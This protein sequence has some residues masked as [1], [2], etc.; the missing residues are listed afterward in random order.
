MI[1]MN[2]LMMLSFLLLSNFIIEQPK[3]QV[4]LNV[5]IGLH[6]NWGPQGVYAEYYYMPE[7]EV[8]YHVPSARF[9]FWGGRDWIFASS[10]P[11]QFG[12]IDLFNA[13]KVIINEPRPYLFHNQIMARYNRPGRWGGRNQFGYDNRYRNEERM[14]RGNYN[15]RDDVYG[16]N[17]GKQERN[18]E[19]GEERRFERGRGRNMEGGHRHW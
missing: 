8:Y 7:Y 16:Y 15:R 19:R 17:Y 1:V 4:R 14:E 9:I 10:L 5:N 6:P 18:E 12:R 13:Y 11:Y 2:K 3:A